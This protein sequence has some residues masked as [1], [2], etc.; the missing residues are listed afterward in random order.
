MENK[1]ID[2]LAGE[3]ALAICDDKVIDIGTMENLATKALGVLQEQGVYAMIVFLLSKTNNKP[4]DRLKKAD[5]ARSAVFC[6]DKL[7]DCWEYSILNFLPKKENTKLSPLKLNI[8]KEASK[9]DQKR[10]ES[11]FREKL[12]K[13][14]RTILDQYINLSNSLEELL[15]VK[16][17]YEQT[18]IYVRHIAKGMKK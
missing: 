3:T 1:S 13:V 6:I 9:D 16:E 14:K 18:L 7:N 17:F 12:L 11:E 2:N 4:F 5:E 15:F 8:P 10:L